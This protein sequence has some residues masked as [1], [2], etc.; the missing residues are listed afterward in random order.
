MPLFRGARE[1]PSPLPEAL[2]VNDPPRRAVMRDPALDEHL[3]SCGYVVVTLM[4][5][6]EAAGLGAEYAA[7]GPAETEFGYRQELY[8][9]DLEL[10]SSRQL[11][12]R[13]A[14]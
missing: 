3:R 11:F 2:S 8:G 1:L 9:N 13:L 14:G 7:L 5:N 12:Q 6:A 10:K 4:S